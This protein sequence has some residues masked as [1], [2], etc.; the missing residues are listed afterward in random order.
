MEEAGGPPS[1]M[2]RWSSV[3]V[4]TGTATAKWSRPDHSLRRVH[5]WDAHPATNSEVQWPT[6]NCPFS[7]SSFS[8][9]RANSWAVKTDTPCATA[10]SVSGAVQRTDTRRLYARTFNSALCVRAIFGFATHVRERS[11]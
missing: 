4:A 5:L 7:R 3:P 8:C 9:Y 11:D 2:G 10:A 1:T 6:G